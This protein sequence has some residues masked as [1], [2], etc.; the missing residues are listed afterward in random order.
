MSQFVERKTKQWRTSIIDLHHE[1]FTPNSLESDYLKSLLRLRNLAL[2]DAITGLNCG[3]VTCRNRASKS[4]EI[5]LS[6]LTQEYADS[7]DP[8]GDLLQCLADFG[9]EP[10]YRLLEAPKE[11]DRQTRDRLHQYTDRATP[12]DAQTA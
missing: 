6:A 1:P 4:L 7:H 11:T 3:C 12:D 9:L 2:S 10:G 8:E 5:Y